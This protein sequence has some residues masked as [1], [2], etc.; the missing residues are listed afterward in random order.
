MEEEI[1]LKPKI[2]LKKKEE[3]APFVFKEKMQIE[4]IWQSNTDLDLCLFWKTLDGS[5]GGVFS[6]EYNQNLKDLGSWD[7]FPYILHSGDE[8]TPRE[9]GESNEIIKIRNLDS[10]A[11]LY[12]VVIN[13]EKAIDMIP[14]TFSQD[15]GRV[16]ITTDEGDFY[17]VPIDD[18]REGHVY[19]ICTITNQNG[20][21]KAVN[22]GEVMSLGQA[23]RN[24]PGFKLITE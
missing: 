17:E 19:L 9:G 16:E 3:V 18:D 2:A 24:I 5:I 14:S 13:Y 11:E 20:I 10:I 1:R 7:S 4:M 8:K 15:S 22:K 21:K 23:F 6:S 12:L